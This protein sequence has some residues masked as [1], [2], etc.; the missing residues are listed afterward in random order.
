[1]LLTL[2]QLTKLA[3]HESAAIFEEAAPDQFVLFLVALRLSL[4]SFRSTVLVA[5]TGLFRAC[6][7]ARIVQHLE[8]GGTYHFAYPESRAAPAEEPIGE[9]FRD[10]P[11]T[12]CSDWGANWL[13]P[14]LAAYGVLRAPTAALFIEYDGYYRHMEPSGLARDMRKTNALR[15]FGPAGS[16]V[17]RIA[18]GN[19]EWRDKS[20]QIEVDTWYPEHSPS[21]FKTVEQVVAFLLRR[22]RGK[23]SA[24]L[25]SRLELLEGQGIDAKGCIFAKQAEVIGTSNKLPQVEKYLLGSLCMTRHDVAKVVASFPPV[26]GYSV[27]ANL[28]PTVEWIKGLGLSQSQV[29]K[30]IATSPPVLG[31]SIEANL[32]P[33]VEW[34]KGLGLSQSQV[35]KVVASCPQVLGYS[36]EAN[37]KPTVEWIKGLGL[38]QSQVAKVVASFPQVLGYSI[39]TNL[40]PTVE[41]IRGLGL[42]Q[43]QVAKVVASFPQVLGLSITTNLA[44]KCNLVRQYF[45]GKSVA[46]L[47]AQELIL[48]TG[49]SSRKLCKEAPRDPQRDAMQ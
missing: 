46:D 10:F 32:K 1:C 17:I 42:S 34:I 12:Q 28:K 43:S 37:L 19:R 36:I 18:H 24:A 20:V 35:A 39:V 7:S 29:A 14:D 22:C 2:A 33:T 47:F 30:V 21:L 3:K 23:L 27:E 15:R 49:G 9:A 40:K 6:E 5:E 38:S 16:L 48:D 41:W 45:V 11:C 25:V 4:A 13:S 8:C 26:L 31:L 44:V